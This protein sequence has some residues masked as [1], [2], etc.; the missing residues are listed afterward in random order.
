MVASG[1]KRVTDAML[2][3]ASRALAREAPL[4][5]QGEGALLPPLSQIRELS[6]A[7]AFEVAAQAQQEGVALKTDG[8]KLRESIERNCWTPEYRRYRRR[9]F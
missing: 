3:T 1:A 8:I 2:M 6:K 9:S 7:I 4:V 5:K